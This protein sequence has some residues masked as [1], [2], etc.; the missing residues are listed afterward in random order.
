MDNG[1]SSYRRYLRG[2]EEA[3]NEII[4]EYFDRLV[5]FINGFVQDFAAAEDIA[6]DVFSDLIV[7]KNR[8]NFKSPLK[9][10][11][12]VLARSRALNYI[13][14]RKLV[15]MVDLEEA[16]H[17][18]APSAEELFLEDQ[19]KKDLYRAL[20]ALEEQQRTAIYLVYLEDLSCTDAAKVMGKSVKQVYNLL[21]RAK[22]KLRTIL[23][24][25][26]LD[27]E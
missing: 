3:F 5:L 6:V 21:Y 11:L 18:G 24:M 12:F 7:H 16:A 13:K 2:D 10:Y 4:K 19:R 1:A 8:Y 15:P 23:G 26:E 22:E 14:R 17:L 25:E 27:D 9:T 20:E